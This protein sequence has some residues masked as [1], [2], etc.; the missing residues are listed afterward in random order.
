[1][2]KKKK[3]PHCPYAG[4]R[5][6]KAFPRGKVANRFRWRLLPNVAQ[7]RERRG[8]RS[9]GGGSAEAK[10]GGALLLQLPA[11][12]R[13][14][15]GKGGRALHAAALAARH[16]LRAPPKAPP[17]RRRLLGAQRFPKVLLALHP[18][19]AAVHASAHCS[20][21]TCAPAAPSARCSR[22]S[23]FGHSGRCAPTAAAASA[24]HSASQPRPQLSAGGGLPSP[25]CAQPLPARAA[26]STASGL[27][28]HAS[29][30]AR[31][32]SQ[33]AAK[34]CPP[35]RSPVR[36]GCAWPWCSWRC[37]VAQRGVE[38]A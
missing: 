35:R 33:K 11:S 23:P 19:R 14:G 28:E 27:A 2:K 22:Y 36:P 6:I 5:R 1:M 29:S 37:S 25:V 31:C 15:C 21:A 32:F 4:L 10:R 24:A 17:P 18:Q 16:L 9:C 38:E 7:P 30:S 8:V 34:S 20:A 13:E 12:R 3:N 26:A